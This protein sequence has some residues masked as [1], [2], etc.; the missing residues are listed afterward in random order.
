[1]PGRHDLVVSFSTPLDTISDNNVYEGKVEWRSGA[2]FDVEILP[3][4]DNRPPCERE[5][6]ATLFV[7]GTY[8]GCTPIYATDSFLMSIEM[9]GQL[10][11]EFIH[12]F[13]STYP[14]GFVFFGPLTMD[15][16]I[17]GQNR[18]R[19]RF[20]HVNDPVPK[21]NWQQ[22]DFFV[23]DDIV[24]YYEETFDSA[25]ELDS[26][27]ISISKGKYLY[28]S[29]QDVNGETSFV[30]SGSSILDE[31]GELRIDTNSKNPSIY[32]FRQDDFIS[33][34]HL[35]YNSDLFIDPVLE[36]ELMHEVSDLDYRKYGS[37]PEL[38]TITAVNYDGFVEYLT[39]QPIDTFEEYEFDLESGIG[40][41]DIRITNL[42]LTG[43][44]DSLSGEIL[45]NSDKV[46]FNY[47]RIRDRAVSSRDP[48]TALFAVSPNPSSN[49]FVLQWPEGKAIPIGLYHVVNETGQLVESFHSSTGT[50]DLILGE[51]WT[52][53]VYFLHFM[54][55]TNKEDN[56][57]VKLVKN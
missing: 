12:P 29:V 7:S 1:M 17:F 37:R 3:I 47:I 16:L 52:S 10:R 35:C 49:T 42:A 15:N 28:H 6:S 4:F 9:N 57:V 39:S 20:D 21:N 27:F 51:E 31:A 44:I 24:S 30:I 48:K 34:I 54:S 13:R 43:M 26:T 23:I 2:D 50:G 11:Q 22:V 19:I 45:S 18:A 55:D 33:E 46:S 25:E 41:T 8:H 40:V 5:N 53:G 32:L 56:Q 14:G 38:A 36:F